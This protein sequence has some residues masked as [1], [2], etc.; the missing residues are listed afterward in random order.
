MEA[1]IP[2]IADHMTPLIDKVRKIIKI[3]RYSPVKNDRLQQFI[4]ESN[5]NN[6]SLALKLDVKTR[7]NSLL[8][9]LRCFLRVLCEIEKTLL[10]LDMRELILLGEEV[11][12]LQGLVDILETI[13][14]GSL[15]MSKNDA[16]LLRADKIIDFMLKKV[17]ESPSQFAAR[18]SGFINTRLLERRNAGIAGLLRSL[19]SPSP[20]SSNLSY[21]TKNELQ[22]KARDLYVRLFW[23]P[24]DSVTLNEVEP[25]ELENDDEGQPKEKKTK[26]D[27]LAV[28]LEEKQEKV[29]SEKLTS[30]ADI[31]S[32]IKREM[33]IFEN[34]GERPALLEKI[35]LAI[36]SLPPTS[37]EAE[38][39]F[40]AAGLFVTKLRTRLSDKTIDTLCFL[41]K[42]IDRI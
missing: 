29:T 30:P 17:D 21:P 10:D 38:R 11:E 7:W 37:V 35:F 3:F 12:M 5:S 1:E 4:K 28:H 13:E 27:E 23:S 31:L 42:N 2:I 33:T 16:D 32:E 22:K 36:K 34:T 26:L 6:A 8:D 18:M 15:S 20:S 24:P 40:S 14:I 19:S 25:C 41:R 39:A 9:M